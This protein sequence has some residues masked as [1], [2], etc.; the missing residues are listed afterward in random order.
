MESFL[1]DVAGSWLE[2]HGSVRR[3]VE[4]NPQNPSTTI[5][6]TSSILEGFEP[7]DCAGESPCSYLFLSF[8]LFS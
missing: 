4:S 5:Y 6:Y 2:E 8:P 3:K 1:A 7:S